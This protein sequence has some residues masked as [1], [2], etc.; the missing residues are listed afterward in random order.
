MPVYICYGIASIGIALILMG[1]IAFIIFI[2][3]S[4]RTRSGKK[5]KLQ[6]EALGIV[7][8]IETTSIFFSIILGFIIVTT[9]MAGIEGGSIERAIEALFMRQPPSP[10]TDSA[11]GDFTILRRKPPSP[12]TDSAK[13]NFTILREQ[14]TI[15]LQDRKEIKTL[16]EISATTRNFKIKI[17]DVEKGVKEVTFCYAT[18]ILAIMPIE[19]PEGARWRRATEESK[20]VVNPFLDLLKVKEGKDFLRT[21]FEDLLSRKGRM[22]TYYITIPI[23]DGENQEISYTLLYCNAFQGRDFEWASEICAADTDTIT[24]RIFF[25]LDKRFETYETYKKF[26]NGEIREIRNP[27]IDTDYESITWNISGAK[28]GERYFIKWDW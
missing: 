18:S 5:N 16:G 13:A 24:M 21:F 4:K 1:V 8:D 11:K 26:P 28:S 19:M 9:S 15:D 12:P 20:E 23:T 6:I 22:K 7:I 27:D 10:P 2:F 25:P 3:G 17:K 14:I